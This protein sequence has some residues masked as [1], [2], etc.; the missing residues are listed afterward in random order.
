[1]IVTEVPSR[2]CDGEKEVMAT[3]RRLSEPDLDTR[4]LMDQ[5]VRAARALLA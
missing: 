4:P 3:I 1:M 5:A 2:P